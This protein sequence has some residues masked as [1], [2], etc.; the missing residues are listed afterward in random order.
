MICVKFVLVIRAKRFEDK[1]HIPH[2]GKSK[3][4]SCRGVVSPSEAVVGLG[5]A[6]FDGEKIAKQ[7]RNAGLPAYSIA[8]F[9]AF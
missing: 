7:S 4:I 5:R 3:T 9:E 8:V 1:A 6:D 2:S